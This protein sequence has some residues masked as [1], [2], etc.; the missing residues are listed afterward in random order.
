M[1]PRLKLRSGLE[2]NCS[3]YLVQ[4]QRMVLM[5]LGVPSLCLP[6]I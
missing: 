5:G 3:L 6:L 2:K 1:L 4:V